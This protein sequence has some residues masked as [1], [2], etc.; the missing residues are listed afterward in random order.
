MQAACEAEFPRSDVLLMAA[1]VADFRPAAPVAHKLKKT[2]AAIPDAIT[3]EPTEDIVE[4]LAAQRHPGQVLVGFA[5]EHGDGAV[6]YGRRKLEAKG[7]D[8]VVVNDI[9][10]ADI[11]FE[12]DVN[13]VVIVTRR[14]E[15]RVP[16]STKEA[17]ADAVLD[18]AQRQLEEA[19]GGA[20]A[21]A[22][23]TARV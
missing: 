19:D 10:R 16:R 13:E 8:A 4:R 22:R 3:L 11:G 7:L 14:D 9:S 20:R 15:R 23:R 21:D 6:D 18:E 5:A 17:V 2:D 1:A 12:S